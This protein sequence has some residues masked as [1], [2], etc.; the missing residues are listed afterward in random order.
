MQFPRRALSD[1][2]LSV[3]V[4]VNG[5][6]PGTVASYMYNFNFGRYTTERKFIFNQVM[7]I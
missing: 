5:S 1:D 4:D 2:S 7:I 3:K 6:I